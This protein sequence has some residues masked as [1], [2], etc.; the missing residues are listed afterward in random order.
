MIALT[1]ICFHWWNLK[2][3]HPPNL[4]WETSFLSYSMDVMRIGSGARQRCLL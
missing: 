3:K 4:F 2:M 1:C